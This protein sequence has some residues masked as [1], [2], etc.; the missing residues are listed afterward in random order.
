MISRRRDLKEVRARLSSG[1]WNRL[2]RAHQA[3]GLACAKTQGEEEAPKHSN[4]GM[5]R[6]TSKWVPHSWRQPSEG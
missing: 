4:K 2:G 3:E 5:S 6:L 1:A